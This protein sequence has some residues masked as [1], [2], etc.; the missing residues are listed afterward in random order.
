[1][2]YP[3]FQILTTS[4]ISTILSFH[5][6]HLIMKPSYLPRL[7]HLEGNRHSLPP[8]LA[9]PSHYP[10]NRHINHFPNCKHTSTPYETSYDDCGKSS[11]TASRKRSWTRLKNFLRILRVI[12]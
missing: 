4:G 2:E 9:R 3:F 12:P 8:K 7:L 6:S 10:K 5:L 11:F 1:M